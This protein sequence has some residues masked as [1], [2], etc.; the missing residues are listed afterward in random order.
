MIMIKKFIISTISLIV[1]ILL[2]IIFT[3]QSDLNA[4]A[5]AHAN[6]I[7]RIDIVKADQAK[8]NCPY[9]N[10]NSCEYLQKARNSKCPAFKKNQPAV[11]TQPVKIIM[12]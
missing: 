7:S 9:L 5:S 10:E 2:T 11:E 8:N 12:L 6:S 4:K 3:G 1:A